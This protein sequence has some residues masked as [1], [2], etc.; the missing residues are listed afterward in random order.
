MCFVSRFLKFLEKL[1]ILGKNRKNEK[2]MENRK[3]K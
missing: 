3:G 2:K 1:E